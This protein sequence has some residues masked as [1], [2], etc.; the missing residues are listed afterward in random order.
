MDEYKYQP[1]VSYGEHDI[2]K[3]RISKLEDQ[4]RELTVQLSYL[5][6]ALEKQS[7]KNHPSAQPHPFDQYP[8]KFGT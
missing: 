4:L 2:C 8:Q 6:I 3:K 5:Q 1:N 7:R